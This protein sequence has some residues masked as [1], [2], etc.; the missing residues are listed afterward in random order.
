[1]TLWL[2]LKERCLVKVHNLMKVILALNN[3]NL[4]MNL[5]KRIKKKKKKGSNSS[6]NRMFLK[7]K[8]S[9]QRKMYSKNRM[10]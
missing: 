5:V 8:K 6:N 4:K 3:S 2:N 1:M 7:K 10:T 9:H